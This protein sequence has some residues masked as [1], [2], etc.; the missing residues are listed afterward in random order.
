VYQNNGKGGFIE[1]T[2]KSSMTKLSDPMSGYSP[3]IADFDNDG[4]KDIFISR[5]DVQSPAMA[6]RRMID[7]PIRYF[8]IF[9]AENGRH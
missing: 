1:I 9:L 6:G 4:W 8:E 7:Q 2:A 3:N 5:G